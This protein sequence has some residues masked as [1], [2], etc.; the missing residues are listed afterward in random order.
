MRST[1]YGGCPEK[2]MQPETSADCCSTGVDDDDG[3]LAE[4]NITH[5]D[6]EEEVYGIYT[7]EG[8]QTRSDE[9]LRKNA[10]SESGNEL[11]LDAL[12][13]TRLRVNTNIND[14]QPQSYHT[15]QFFS[16]LSPQ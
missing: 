6:G 2:V 9:A 13:T 12:F 3:R 15:P 7:A 5:A 16:F 8:V 1:H 11:H 4:G 14:G 10:S